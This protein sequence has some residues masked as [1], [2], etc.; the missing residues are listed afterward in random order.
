MA[1]SEFNLRVAL[2]LVVSVE[3]TYEKVFAEVRSNIRERDA[4]ME[5]ADF[6]SWISKFV[7][8]F[9][10]THREMKDIHS[11]HADLDRAVAICD[12]VDA[13]VTIP[14]PENPDVKL[15]APSVKAMALFQKGILLRN[16]GDVQNAIEQMNQSLRVEPD[17]ATLYNI[18]QF[19][20]DLREQRGGQDGG[21]G[22]TVKKMLTSGAE[23]TDQ[24]ID[25]FRQCVSMNSES[26]IAVKAGMELARL[27]QL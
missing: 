20:I 17:Q 21:L 1:G 8:S 10:S 27:E 4:E 9:F 6:W 15:G 5:R 13:N 24:A 18:G 25:A 3:E 16:Q 11:L 7:K 23:Q 2:G 22:A 26:E 14:N 12:A 19:F